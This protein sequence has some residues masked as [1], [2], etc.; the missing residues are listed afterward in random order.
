MENVSLVIGIIS[1]AACVVTALLAYKVHRYNRTG[2][3][4]MGVVIAFALMFFR[5]GIGF[6]REFGMYSDLKPMMLLAE[7]VLQVII[8]LLFIWGFWCML[9]NF[10]RFD[11]VEKQSKEKAIGFNKKGKR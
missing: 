1:L 2:M 6:V 5:R 7:N 4:F 11:V 9:K 8:S 10:E 3:G